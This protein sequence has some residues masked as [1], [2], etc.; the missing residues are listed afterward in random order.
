MNEKVK[1]TV[2]ADDFSHAG[3]VSGKVRD[4]MKKLPIDAEAVRRAA[5][6]LYEGEINM[7]IHSNGGE[8]DVEV[9]DR[10][11]TMTLSVRGPGIP[12][13]DLATQEG[14]STAGESARSMGFGA[15]MGFASM[16]KHT[17]YM[18]IDSRKGIGT[19]ITMKIY[20]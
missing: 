13:V 3:D 14:Y 9:S 8:I 10:C 2:K 20:F 1:Y 6:A 17:D 7:I 12:D 11:I 16:K 18:M 15:G 5:I 19:T 4:W